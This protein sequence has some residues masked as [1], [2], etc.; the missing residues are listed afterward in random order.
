MAR[1]LVNLAAANV[2]SAI[3]HEAESPTQHNASPSGQRIGDDVQRRHPTDQ[4]PV[5]A[6]SGTTPNTVC[7]GG[8]YKTTS[9]I[10]NE[11][12]TAANK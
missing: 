10:T 11:A 8:T 9:C 6:A 3:L 2:Y 12:A 7:N 4:Q 5:V 1:A